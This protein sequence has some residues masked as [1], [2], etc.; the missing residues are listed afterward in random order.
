MLSAQVARPTICRSV[1]NLM[2]G[3]QMQVLTS[4]SSDLTNSADRVAL[5]RYR[6]GNEMVAPHQLTLRPLETF[7]HDILSP[8]S[9][10]QRMTIDSSL[11]RVSL[12]PFA[13]T[14]GSST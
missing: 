4:F 8:N 7:C 1:T 10:N 14:M 2:S 5:T 11:R 9:K 12:S 3:L 6:S 13:R